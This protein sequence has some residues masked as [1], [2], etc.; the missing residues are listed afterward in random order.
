MHPIERNLLIVRGVDSVVLTTMA[1][2]LLIM[3]G[4]FLEV[5]VINLIAIIAALGGMLVIYAGKLPLKVLLFGPIVLEVTLML[6]GGWFLIKDDMESFL[7]VFLGSEALL[8]LI[9]KAR[10]NV[11]TAVVS[12]VTNLKRYLDK[13]HTVGSAATI[14]G[15]LISTILVKLGI[16]HE[17]IIGAAYLSL[18]LVVNVVS[19]RTNLLIYRLHPK[20]YSDGAE[21]CME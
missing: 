3:T 20:I 16:T 21:V 11:V 18:L 7:I 8:A 15:M 10:A 6:P 9:W 17:V 14:A 2:S 5:E 13:M 4:R 12:K 1:T 19:L